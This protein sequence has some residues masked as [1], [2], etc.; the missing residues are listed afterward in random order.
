MREFCVHVCVCVS[1]CTYDRAK[2]LNTLFFNIHVHNHM[3]VDAA[4]CA[5]R[6]DGGEAN[7]D[8]LGT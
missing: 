1:G 2:D 6:R 8:E 7:R 5:D 4:L 3:Q